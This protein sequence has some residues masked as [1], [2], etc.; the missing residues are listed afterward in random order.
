MAPGKV[1]QVALKFGKYVILTAVACGAGG[2]DDGEVQGIGGI[3]GD[4]C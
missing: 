2:K 1:S 3:A 4:P